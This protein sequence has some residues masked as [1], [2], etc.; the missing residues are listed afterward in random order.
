[1][2]CVFNVEI[3][4]SILG[5]PKLPALCLVA[6]ECLSLLGSPYSRVLWKGLA[7]LPLKFIDGIRKSIV[8]R[9]CRLN[10]NE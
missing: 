5:P 10:K 2:F 6:D 4:L 7:K 9:Y 3:S 8:N 1:M